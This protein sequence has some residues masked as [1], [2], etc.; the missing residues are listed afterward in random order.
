MHRLGVIVDGDQFVYKTDGWKLDWVKARLW[1]FADDEVQEVAPFFINTFAAAGPTGA[2]I[3]F[4]RAAE[5]AGF[6]V[7]HRPEKIGES[8]ANT[9]YTRGGLALAGGL[10]GVL[11]PICNHIALHARGPSLAPIIGM[12]LRE[13]SELVIDII[14]NDPHPDLIALAELWKGRL[15]IHHP[16]DAKERLAYRDGDAHATRDGVSTLDLKGIRLRY[17]QLRAD[18]GITLQGTGKVT[19]FGNVYGWSKAV[20]LPWDGLLDHR[21][22]LRWCPPKHL[23]VDKDH[24]YWIVPI[25]G[26]KTGDRREAI[27]SAAAAGWH[28]DEVPVVR[29]GDRVFAADD[30]VIAHRLAVCAMWCR[31]VVLLSGDRDFEAVMALLRAVHPAEFTRVALPPMKHPHNCTSHRVVASEHATFVPLDTILDRVFS[32]PDREYPDHLSLGH[33]RAGGRNRQRQLNSER[34]KLLQG[35]VA[36]VL[37]TIQARAR[38]QNQSVIPATAQRS[39]RT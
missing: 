4:E 39:S 9:R 30:P 25:K 21:K 18:A 19:D 32:M 23:V 15:A 3:A 7:L 31:H 5:R 22:V 28:V 10:L 38:W 33:V 26:N 2:A 8:E 17:A 1:P 27:T 20:G 14:A 16:D 24:Q 37:A 13:H 36:S 11:A 29:D 35:H 34:A 12:A 6:T